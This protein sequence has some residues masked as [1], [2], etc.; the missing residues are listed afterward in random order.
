[1]ENCVNLRKCEFGVISAPFL[2]FP[3]H[4]THAVFP[5]GK[6]AIICCSRPKGG[7]TTFQKKIN[8]ILEENPHQMGFVISD[9][10][11]MMMMNGGRKGGR[12][13]CHKNGSK[14]HLDRTAIKPTN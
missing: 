9:V 1:M 8:N 11:M 5:K 4:V 6:G 7:Q 10:M 3:L 14:P 2:P 13:V 12:D